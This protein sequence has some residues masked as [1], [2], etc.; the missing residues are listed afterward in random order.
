[1]AIKNDNDD[2]NDYHEN[3]NGDDDDD[4]DDN[5]DDDEDYD[6]GGCGNG[7][8]GDGDDCCQVN[9]AELHKSFKF[10]QV[11]TWCCQTRSHYV[12]KCWPRSTL[13]YGIISTKS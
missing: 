11:M 10:V 8:D 7:G 13:Q 5:D 12:S 3:G 6:D 2:D 1:M 9:T 4:D